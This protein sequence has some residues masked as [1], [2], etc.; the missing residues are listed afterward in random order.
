METIIKNMISNGLNDE[1]IVKY[2]G[3]K[4]EIITKLRDEEQ[5]DNN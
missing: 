2:T 3:A 5:N 1:D 4:P